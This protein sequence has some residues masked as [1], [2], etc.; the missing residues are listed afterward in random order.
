M[1][2]C[3]NNCVPLSWKKPTPDTVIQA[4][5]ILSNHGVER[6]FTSGPATDW[7]P[8]PCPIVDMEVAQTGCKENYSVNCIA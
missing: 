4:A 5:R 6:F 8:Y 7:N 1:P 3:I 2:M